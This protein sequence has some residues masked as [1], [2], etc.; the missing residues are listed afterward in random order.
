LG[1]LQAERSF[2][3][4]GVVVVKADVFHVESAC[5]EGTFPATAMVVS[6]DEAAPTPP[7]TGVACCV[8]KG[9]PDKRST[10]VVVAM[11]PV[12][13]ALVALSSPGPWR[14]I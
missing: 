5:G 3:V 7:L 10:A 2:T 8:I 4:G 1:A 14:L 11:T 13:D 12:K 9:V 6:V